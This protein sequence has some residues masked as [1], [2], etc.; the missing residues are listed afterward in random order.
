[1]TTYTIF[2]EN[3]QKIKQYTHGSVRA[4]HKPLLLLFAL[5]RVH[6]NDTRLI[7]YQEVDQILGQLLLD[8][9]PPS[10]V[11]RPNTYDPFRRLPNDSL[12]E[13]RDNS[14]SLVERPLEFERRRLIDEKIVG[15][16]PEEFFRLLKTD[17][18]LLQEA[19]KMILDSNWPPSLH[20]STM[21]AVGLDTGVLEGM[22][23]F[24]KSTTAVRRDPKFREKVLKAYERT[25]AV[26]NF[27]LR[28]NDT[29][30]DLQAAHI[31]WHSAG[32]PDSPTNGIALCGFHHKAF[33]R[34]AMGFK[35]L[36]GSRDGYE[37]MISQ[38]LNGSSIARDWLLDYNGERVRNPQN[39]DQLP[40]TKFVEWHADQV[41][42]AP[43]R[44]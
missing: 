4:P 42:H 12:W 29:L 31:K 43:A 11:S 14:G 24:R 33:D 19:V 17:T 30:L 38:S 2:L 22:V 7:S 25:C 5:A 16:F 9:G 8:W 40:E 23:V 27:D 44:S 20:D 15:G 34:G 41:F 28:L 1:M 18:R 32:G 26:C 35:P 3:L 6:R 21:T 37:I 39:L 13:L 10:K 36:S